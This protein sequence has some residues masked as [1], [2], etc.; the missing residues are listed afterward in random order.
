MIKNISDLKE[1]LIYANKS[2]KNRNFEKAEKLYKK[3]LKEFPKNFD[4]N[5]FLASI[6]VQKN[7]YIKLKIIWR[8][9]FQ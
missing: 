7:N 2:F 9:L 6:K 3:I 8:R 1:N 4:A 5:Y